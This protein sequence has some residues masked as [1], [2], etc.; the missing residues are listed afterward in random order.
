MEWLGLHVITC[1]E[2]TGAETQCIFRDTSADPVHLS[3]VR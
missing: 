1:I 2:L 3:P